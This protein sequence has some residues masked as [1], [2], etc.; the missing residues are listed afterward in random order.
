MQYTLKQEVK[1]CK[2]REYV[3][4][5]KNKFKEHINNPKQAWKEAKEQM[6]GNTQINPER[7]MENNIMK[8]G[9][10]NVANILN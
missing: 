7:M 5:K 1:Q 2:T 9:S 4:N 8:V 6:Y 10:K 3:I